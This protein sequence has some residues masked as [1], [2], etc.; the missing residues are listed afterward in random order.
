[1]VFSF[2]S[3]LGLFKERFLFTLLIYASLL[4]GVSVYNYGDTGVP[5]FAF[6]QIFIFFLI[7]LRSIVSKPY[8]NDFFVLKKG[9]TRQFV[10]LLG[11]FVFLSISSAWTFPIIFEGTPVFNPKMGI[12]SQYGY[13]NQSS[14]L[15]SLSNLAQ[16]IYIFL[17][18]ITFLYVLNFTLKIKNPR[19]I[20]SVFSSTLLLIL[21]LFAFQAFFF[22]DGFNEEA[23]DIVERLFFNN[24]SY[25]I[26]YQQVTS[27][28][29]PRFSGPFL[30]P[31]NAGLYLAGL[32]LSLIGLMFSFSS[33]RYCCIFLVALVA[34]TTLVLT[35]SSSGYVA[36][37]ISFLIY[38]IV[39][40]FKSIIPRKK[41]FY[42]LIFLVFFISLFII[43]YAHFSHILEFVIFDKMGSD[44]YL[45]RSFSN[46]FAI[47]VWANTYFLGAGLGS[48]RPSSFFYY[49]LS[50]LGFLSLIFLS[51]LVL[52]LYRSLR[53][54]KNEMV[55]FAFLFLLT[56][57]VGMLVAVPDISSPFLW[58]LMA[59]LLGFQD[60][61]L[62]GRHDDRG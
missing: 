2:L 34:F 51:L 16:S 26:L 17:N 59:M 53:F 56:V 35:T 27:F 60:R 57:F 42:A 36:F 49:L 19:F 25:A 62:K 9:F 46:Q 20:I 50:N 13:G 21:A 43:N 55:L 47:E 54:I 37:T 1:M 39:Y 10:F 4:Q 23:I 52:L 22:I 28:G 5:V 15:F 45:H 61:I 41:L 14:L 30:E 40:L 32:S 29:M 31:S 11:M 12:D 18:F 24:P 48:N 3:F 7:L 44:S 33:R 38:L 6:I 58:Y 8:L